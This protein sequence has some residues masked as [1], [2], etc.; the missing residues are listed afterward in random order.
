MNKRRTAAAFRTLHRAKSRKSAAMS[1]FRTAMSRKLPPP[2]GHFRPALE[3]RSFTLT[4]FSRRSSGIGHKQSMERR[5]N[6]AEQEFQVMRKA[7]I[8]GLLVATAAVP[9]PTFAQNSSAQTREER[10]QARQEARKERR[11]TNQRAP[12]EATARQQRQE[13]RMQRQQARQQQDAARAEAAARQQRQ[14]R[15]AQ[16]V[17]QQPE[18]RGQALRG[19]L[20]DPND[21]RMEEHRRRYERLARQNAR[22][23]GTR[24]QYRSVVQRQRAERVERRAERREDRQDWRQDRRENRREWRQERREDRREARQARREWNRDW[25]RE[26]RY[27]WRA[28]RDRNR[29][30]F[31]APTYYAPYRGYGYTRFGIGSV[32]D[33]GFWGRNYWI[34]DPFQF[35]L[36][37]APAGYVWVRYYDDVLL[38]DT[39]SGRIVDVIHN[40]FW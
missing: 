20:G 23:N 19:W 30:I 6:A 2:G 22:E 24:E 36:P 40:F 32:L 37:P 13:R 26:Q 11:Q 7:F 33:R 15:R 38:V 18:Q 28:F 21:P 16:R 9:A 3:R 39:W 1:G 14:E 31:R 25:R 35:R 17:Q 10:R 5:M 34:N 27:D 8:L 12:G 29:Y 4:Q